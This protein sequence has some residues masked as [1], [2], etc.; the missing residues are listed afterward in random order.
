MS[1]TETNAGRPQHD[2]QGQS[3]PAIR[4]IV[5]EMKKPKKKKAKRQAEGVARYSPALEDL[6]VIGGDALRASHRAANALAKGIEAYERERQRSANEKKDGALKDFVYNAGKATSVWLKETS[7]IPVD[8][9]EAM[10]R[11]TY[12]KRLRKRLRRVAKL[13]RR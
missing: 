9:T 3:G 2:T 1:K 10:R 5:F 8:L 11:R 13:L 4:P 6:Q 12:G 7:D